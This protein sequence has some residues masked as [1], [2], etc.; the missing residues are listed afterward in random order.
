MKI[1][2]LIALL[3]V[4]CSVQ[5]LAAEVKI[6]HLSTNKLLETLPAS[7]KVAAEL[8]TFGEQLDQKMKTLL[9]TYQGKLAAFREQAKNWD[10]ARVQQAQA[11]IAE[12]QQNIKRLQADIQSDYQQR[13]A[14]LLRPVMLK[15][16]HAIAE[17]ATSA[18]Y[19]HVFDMDN[20][21]LI[22]AEEQY[23][24]QDAV[25]QKFNEL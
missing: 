13:K 22:Y 25:G 2:L 8:K 12:L 24:I 11:E 4:L 9:E 20:G 5:S 14:T 21:T 7:K 10:Q 17:V 19:T 15:L 1:R 23:N 16:H 6:G 3:L 18:G